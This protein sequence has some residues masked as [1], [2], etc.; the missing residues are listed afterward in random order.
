MLGSGR[1]GRRERDKSI[2]ALGLVVTS[3]SLG[4]P[5]HP[6]PL[7]VAHPGNFF[8]PPHHHAA[9]RREGQE[10]GLKQVGDGAGSGGAELRQCVHSHARNV[11]IQALVKHG[12]H[13]D[14]T[15]DGLA[16]IIVAA[17][18]AE[19]VCAEHA[20]L[21]LHGLAQKYCMFVQYNSV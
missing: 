20:A 10:L 14:R 2:T 13:P 9:V 5:L 12:V 16:W 15:H 19:V 17:A 6:P 18:L 7:V 1:H 3:G 8:E 21:E 4:D 11:P